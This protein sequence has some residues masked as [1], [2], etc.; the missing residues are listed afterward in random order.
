MKSH[1]QILISPQLLAKF[2]ASVAEL[3]YLYLWRR[4]WLEFFW[5]PSLSA[6]LNGPKTLRKDFCFW[7]NSV[8]KDVLFNNYRFGIFH[9][10]LNRQAWGEDYFDKKVIDIIFCFGKL[11]TLH[12]YWLYYAHHCL[13]HEPKA[14]YLCG[15]I[16]MKTSCF[17][18]QYWNPDSPTF[19]Q[20]V[21]NTESSRCSNS[22]FSST[23]DF[24]S[25]LRFE[26]KVF[27]CWWRFRLEKFW[28]SCLCGNPNG[29]KLQW[30]IFL[31]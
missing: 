15:S 6:N 7:A 10:D 17:C 21:L 14:F 30:N 26:T 1:I 13:N 20:S 9:Q 2:F 16:Q 22:H 23:I 3:K 31:L 19:S 11:L 27:Y 28:L 8:L 24:I 4:V 25:C 12:N 18:F 29:P 5:F